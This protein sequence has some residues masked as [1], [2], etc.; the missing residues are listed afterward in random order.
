MAEQKN[1]I[2]ALI[3]SVIFTGIGNVYN[4][5]TMRGIVEFV[6]GFVINAIGAFVLPIFTY[7]GI[8]WWIYALYDTYVCTNAI[9]NNQAIPK[10]LTQFD[11]E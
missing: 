11:L 1:L 6:I 3:L 7:V 10:F 8:I 5:L 4:G 2:I 9:N